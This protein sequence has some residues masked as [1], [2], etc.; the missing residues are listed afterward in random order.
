[1]PLLTKV[2][3]GSNILYNY[4]LLTILLVGHT[5][6]PQVFL[7]FNHHR[8]LRG[9]IVIKRINALNGYID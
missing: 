1:M 8:T 2:Q 4:Y 3:L 7:C 6:D 9:A 5:Y